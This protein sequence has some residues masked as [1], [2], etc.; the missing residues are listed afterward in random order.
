MAPTLGMLTLDQKSSRCLPHLLGLELGVEDGELG[1]HAHVRSLQAQRRLQH[2][3]QLLKVAPVLG[4]GD[5]RIQR[6]S[7]Y[8]HLVVTHRPI[9]H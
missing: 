9:S 6:S 3:D 8:N 7:I 2:G 1:E 4:R 5:G